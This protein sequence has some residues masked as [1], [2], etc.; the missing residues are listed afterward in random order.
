MCSCEHIHT[1]QPTSLYVCMDECVFMCVYIYICVQFRLVWGFLRSKMHICPTNFRPKLHNKKNINVF[2]AACEFC[3][4][5]S[6]KGVPSLRSKKGCV[7]HPVL[8]ATDSPIFFPLLFVAT[9]ANLP[10]LH[11]AM[12][13]QFLCQLATKQFWCK[14]SALVFI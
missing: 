1:F 14:L 11:F 10:A 13:F 9:F 5:N 4:P 2:P 6:S 3:H 8:K 12:S 7:P